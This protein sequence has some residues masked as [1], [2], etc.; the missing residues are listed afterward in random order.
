[1]TERATTTTT[2]TKRKRR[3]T[4]CVACV[5][6]GALLHPSEAHPHGLPARP[7]P[8]CHYCFMDARC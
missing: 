3:A 8:A 1:M 4:V 2:T 7:Q 5:L 6:C